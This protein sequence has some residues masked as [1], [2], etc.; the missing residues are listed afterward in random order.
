MTSTIFSRN[1]R[2]RS[3]IQLLL[4]LRT[5]YFLLPTAS[6]TLRFSSTSC[7]FHFGFALEF[8]VWMTACCTASGLVGAILPSPFPSIPRTHSNARVWY[9]LR[10]IGR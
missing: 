2:L 10:S 1:R 8:S 9:F 5:R 4:T 7:M 3:E 6:T